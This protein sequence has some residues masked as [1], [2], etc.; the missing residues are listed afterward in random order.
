MKRAK[1]KIAMLIATALVV[2][3]S[4]GATYAF[5]TAQT[6]K[7]ENTFTPSDNINVDIDGHYGKEDA[8][9]YTSNQL[10]EKDPFLINTTVSNEHNDEYVA[11]ELDYYIADEAGKLQEVT[12]EEF[13]KIASVYMTD[14]K[15]KG[16]NSSWKAL[17]ESE[18]GANDRFYYYGTS[19]KLEVLAK[20]AKTSTIFDYVKID[21]SLRL[22]DADGK[23]VVIT[24]TDVNGNKFTAKGMPKFQI[25]VKGF[26]VQADNITTAEAE[27]EL[28][29]M[30]KAN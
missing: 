1:K 25:D 10:I 7:K 3:V 15:T 19:G 18:N 27:A 20:D 24:L 22:Q 5:L 2:A 14:G 8:K 23:D 6:D 9:N 29:S 13:N 16:F 4:F 28:L 11:I 17:T 30:M 21:P 26:A 12:Y